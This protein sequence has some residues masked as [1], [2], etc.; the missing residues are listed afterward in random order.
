MK[1]EFRGAQKMASKQEAASNSIGLGTVVFLILLVGKVFFHADI[2]WFWVF[3]PLWIG[4][5]IVFG[6]VVVVSIL[7]MLLALIAAVLEK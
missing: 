7:A 6:F 2:T 1:I 4:I 5:A 3:F